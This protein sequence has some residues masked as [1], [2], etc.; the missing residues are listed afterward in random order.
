[1]RYVN[2]LT[3]A[4]KVTLEELM[5][6]N[7][8]ARVRV[9]AHAVLLSDRHFKVNDIARIYAVDRDTASRWL[10]DWETYGLMGLYD[11]PRCGR[12]PKLSAH[13]VAQLN[14]LLQEDPRSIKRLALRVEQVFHKIV[15]LDTL[16]R[17]ARRSGLVWKRIR[18]SLKD[19]REEAA[20]RQAQLE[21]KQLRE[22][23][24]A[25][26]IDL[27]F[28]DETGFAL[29]P[30]IPYAWQP[31]GRTIG[32]IPSKSQRLNVLGFFSLTNDFFSFVFQGRIDAQ[33]VVACFEA[34]SK[35]LIKPTWIIIDNAAQH[36]A[37]IFKAQLADWEKRGLF[38]KYL[39]A[40]SPELNLI[41][42][43]WRFIKYTWLPLSAYIDFASLKK[44]VESILENIGTKYLITF[45]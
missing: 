30:M 24:Q 23:Q 9:R 13:E 3:E 31:K 4:E 19:K 41:E 25:G 22:E 26:G 43:L 45:A 29:A 20:F 8:Y 10:S 37:N 17:W 38:I 11:E 36:T 12:P 28:F 35:T 40:Y 27:Y 33:V 1:M 44:A 6:N 39:P 18:K 15:S 34:F 21:I 42:I 7:N 16:K 32:L 14:D 2:A 5:K